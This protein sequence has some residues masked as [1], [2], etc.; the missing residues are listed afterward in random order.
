[1][2]ITRLFTYLFYTIVATV[3][4]NQCFSQDPTLHTTIPSADSLK[5]SQDTVFRIRNLNPYFTLHVDSTLNYKL[6]INKDPSKY[7]W[8]L[9]NSPIGLKINKDNG[10]LSFKA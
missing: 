3:F 4:T 7:F 1:M 10:L 8:F 5:I 2:N 6:E 9:K